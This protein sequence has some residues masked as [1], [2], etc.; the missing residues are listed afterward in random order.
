MSHPLQNISWGVVPITV[1]RSV[2]VSRLIGGYRIGTISVKTVEE[3][4]K[5]IDEMKFGTTLNDHDPN[6]DL[7]DFE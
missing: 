2:V 4:D 5:V 7:E 6:V 1:Y 3:V